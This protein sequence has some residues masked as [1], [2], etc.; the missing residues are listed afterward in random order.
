[1]SGKSQRRVVTVGEEEEEAEEEIQSAITEV[2]ESNRHLMEKYERE[3][4]LRKKYHDQLVELRG[5]IR[6]LCRVK[7]VT[8]CDQT[9]G[10]CLEGVSADPSV[11][12]RV[13]MKCKGRMRTFELD[14]VFSSQATQEE[15]FEEIEPLVT[16][17]IDGYNIC[18]F[19][20]GQTGSGKTYTM[21]ASGR[22]LGRSLMNLELSLGDTELEYR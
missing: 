11:D 15:V 21:E 4:L 7:P 19:A 16:S 12:C 17:C 8:E 2:S 14:K 22:E 9:E 5:N 10:G 6:V 18:I 20:Y 3:M 1:M 13:R